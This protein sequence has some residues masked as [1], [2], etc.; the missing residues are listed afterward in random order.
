MATAL[1]DG[2]NRGGS[3][4]SDFWYLVNIGIRCL[5]KGSHLGACLQTSNWNLKDQVSSMNLE[6]I[7]HLCAT[8]KCLSFLPNQCATVF[9]WWGKLWVGSCLPQLKLTQHHDFEDVL[10]VPKTKWRT[11]KHQNE[12]TLPATSTFLPRNLDSV[13]DTSSRSRRFRYRIISTIQV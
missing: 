12:V 2:S 3:M 5:S 4:F 8:F 1:S 10:K 11:I 7:C 6:L 9:R 13:L